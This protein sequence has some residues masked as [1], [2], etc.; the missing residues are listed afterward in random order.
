MDEKQ[1]L[2]KELD[3]A[4]EAMREVIAKIDRE[5]ELSPGWTIRH[6]LAHIAGWDDATI[7]SLRAH[8]DG[9]QPPVPAYRGIDVF[10]AESVKSRQ[11]LD[12]EQTCQE[13]EEVRDK[14]KA[15]IARM[16]AEKLRAR[17]IFPWGPYEDT[18]IELIQVI[19]VHERD[20]AEEIKDHLKDSET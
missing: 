18:A 13:F 20:H 1:H 17:M 16:S 9:T 3:A 5:R 19:I 7:D 8:I 4:R 6:V 14:L 15:V 10:N 2:L 11:H 12:Y